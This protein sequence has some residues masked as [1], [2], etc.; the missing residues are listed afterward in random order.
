LAGALTYRLDVYLLAFFLAPEQVA[1]YAIATAL[2]EIAWY[3]PDTVGLVL[4]PR[5]SHMPHQEIHTIT[6]RVCRSTVSLTLIVVLV[7]GS[8]S[9][10]FVPFIYGA[11]YKASVAPLL[12]LL[13][14]IVIM[15]IYKVLTRN[16]SSIDRQQVSIAAAF[17]ALALSLGLNLLL[18]P[19]W[20]VSGAALA[21]TLGYTAA[22]LM[23]MVAFRRDSGLS[24]SDMLLPRISEITGHLRWARSNLLDLI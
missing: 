24:Y 5:L 18:I 11:A 21:S 16:Y 22:G 9:W 10:F 3:I 1:Y 20:G 4:F 6:A 7:I 23:M 12:I 14:G 2:A 8:V 17:T 13:P 15:G 19:L